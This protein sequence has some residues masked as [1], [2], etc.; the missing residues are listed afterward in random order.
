M[1]EILQVEKAVLEKLK[2]VLQENAVKNI[3]LINWN[4]YYTKSQ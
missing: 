3:I 2:D 1:H 4:Y